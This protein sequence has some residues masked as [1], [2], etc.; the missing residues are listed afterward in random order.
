MPP[1]PMTD[2]KTEAAEMEKLLEELQDYNQ[3]MILSVG[4]MVKETVSC[5]RANF[6]TALISA[7]PKLNAYIRTLQSQNKMLEEHAEKVAIY[8]SKMENELAALLGTSDKTIYMKR[9]PKFCD[10]R[11][12]VRVRLLQRIVYEISS[13]HHSPESV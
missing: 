2:S 4:A 13:L 11:M 6:A 3:S 9:L 7:Y 5:G 10:E 8:K 1:P 12:A